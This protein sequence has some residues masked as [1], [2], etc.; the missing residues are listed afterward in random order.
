[1]PVPGTQGAP[2]FNGK[3]A[4]EFLD[5]IQALAHRA[6]VT[7]EN[8]MVN[9]ITTY[10]SSA[11]KKVIRHLPEFDKDEKSKKWKTASDSLLE[12]YESTT[13]APK[14]TLEDLSD[15]CQAYSSK[16]GFTSKRDI[17]TYRQGFLAIAAP[18][19]K[20]KRATDET[21]QS[22][23]VPGI[24]DNLKD[25]FM[26]RLPETNR[27]NSNPP[28]IQDSVKILQEK[29]DESSVVYKP[30]VCK[31][32]DKTGKVHFEVDEEEEEDEEE[33]KENITP[34]T[35]KDTPL[36]TS[37]VKPT[38]NF[39]TKADID[40][41]SKQLEM[42]TLKILAGESTSG[43]QPDVGEVACFI[44]GRFHPFPR[45]PARC[46]EMPNLLKEDLVAYD[47]ERR[48][49]LKKNGEELPRVPYGQPGGIAAMLRSEKDPQKRTEFRRDTPPHQ[50]S[51]ASTS[52]IGLSYGRDT[53]LG[54]NVFAVTSLTPD[55]EDEDEDE[56]RYADYANVTPALRSGRD[57]SARYDP[58]DRTNK[59]KKPERSDKPE[60]STPKAEPTK[61]REPVNTE[62]APEKAP[63][64]NVEI[65]PPSNPIN[66]QEG[67]KRSQPSKDKTS[68]DA[69][70][71]DGTKKA[72]TGPTYHFTSDMQEN[73]DSKGIFSRVLNQQITVTL[74][75]LIGASPT[76]QKMVSDATRTRRE[77]NTTG[78]EASRSIIE[79]FDPFVAREEEEDAL[80]THK[81]RTGIS[82]NLSVGADA[83]LN[84]VSNFM[85]RYSLAVTSIPSAKY[86]AMV[87]G[88]MDIEVNGLRFS[89]MIDTGSELNIASVDFPTRA[90][91][92]LDYEGMK[93]SLKGIH[94]GPEQLA[95]VV[96][97]VPFRLGSHTF[98]HHVFVSRHFISDKYDLIL[99]QPFLQWYA[100]RVEYFRTGVVK[101]YLWKDA[102][103]ER[104]PTVMINITDPSDPRNTTV[105]LGRDQPCS[106]STTND[107]LRAQVHE[108]NEETGVWGTDF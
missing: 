108:Y 69:N 17:E 4:D 6:G 35:A 89:A 84:K 11:V 100:S 34:S 5:I 97:D 43:K 82:K 30:W 65:P 75:E 54:G 106:H 67:W 1:M 78:K 53:V 20:N 13:E 92:P 12:I 57:K 19:K 42:L 18:L 59:G 104:R 86:Y 58:A 94:G 46:P 74:G 29:F 83:D 52:A 27:K 85:L 2:L 47:V 91:L 96:T 26:S 99:G 107:V 32:A 70:M 76:L 79:T 9:Y 62:K 24:P 10:S 49:Y 73:L 77:Y 66:T 22:Y 44:C 36:T 31:K 28:K 102:E 25:W 81:Q 7:D 16:T 50:Q 8:K 95:G 72:P 98:P 71:K 80:K 37:N 64:V 33:E 21:V 15:Y 3:D 40:T 61:P 45:T 63:A 55:E 41:L 87:T 68:Q 38:D 14:Y 101:M 51:S 90:C 93:W 88:V 39:V 105:I 103:K 23:F 60:A 48:R 56:D